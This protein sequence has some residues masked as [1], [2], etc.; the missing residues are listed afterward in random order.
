MAG[1]I[2]FLPESLSA[3]PRTTSPDITSNPNEIGS[4]DEFLR[5]LASLNAERSAESTLAQPAGNAAPTQAAVSTSLGA[6][7]IELPAE[8]QR[9]NNDAEIAAPQSQLTKAPFTDLAETAEP[10]T[11]EASRE[12]LS[13]KARS[14]DTDPIGRLDTNTLE[15]KNVVIAARP[16]FAEIDLANP[17]APAP[18]LQAQ[19][20]S[21][22]E[23]VPPTKL[24]S[25]EPLNPL[26]RRILPAEA[27]SQFAPTPRGIS[28]SGHDQNPRVEAVTASPQH[29]EIN[30]DIEIR[31]PSQTDGDVPPA[32][33][34]LR[35]THQL[36]RMQTVAAFTPFQQN[37][38]TALPSGTIDLP[39]SGE[40]PAA[41]VDPS[42]STDTGLLKDADVDL[43]KSA[44]ADLPKTAE[45][46]PAQTVEARASQESDIGLARSIPTDRAS[47]SKPQSNPQTTI[48]ETSPNAPLPNAPAQDVD[49]PITSPLPA[50]KKA[51]DG[52]R[53]AAGTPSHGEPVRGTLNTNR[54]DASSGTTP[55]VDPVGKA[56]TDTPTQQVTPPQPRPEPQVKAVDR[57]GSF[58]SK[59]P[60]AA[61]QTGATER[62]SSEPVSADTPR[63]QQS[64]AAVLPEQSVNGAASTEIARETELPAPRQVETART[65]DAKPA[66]EAAPLP[67]PQS[68]SAETVPGESKQVSVV[69]TTLGTSQPSQTQAAARVQAPTFAA[70]L[71]QAGTVIPQSQ[72]ADIPNVMSDALSLEDGSKKI[73]VQLDPPEL[74]RVSID[75]KFDGNVL[76][77]VLVTG[78]TPEAMRRLRLMHFELVQTLESHGFSGQDLDFSQRGDDRRAQ[79]LFQNF[80]EGAQTYSQE[81]STDLA[82]MDQVAARQTITTEGLNLKL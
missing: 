74:G 49:A 40:I 62:A 46:V 68:L 72:V 44:E 26:A 21:E 61:A 43:I 1:Q 4:G 31:R 65:A 3:E 35:P 7:R 15:P 24:E 67:A 23:N 56:E 36:S 45:I 6:S 57:T 60:N 17:A 70:Q 50:N 29:I 81:D 71:Q 82:N 28:T 5:T 12:S 47:A 75:F 18:D 59:T 22:A 58:Q 78:E 11:F 51:T 48:Q 73:T 79:N 30:Q 76:Q 20:P 34:Q 69:E 54:F 2:G 19:V 14:N 9:I 63:R 8:F 38:A 80:E 55:I 13:L 39:Q 42:E 41:I 77:N 64:D 53:P 37:A 25:A 10:V 52:Q 33:S 66:N 16:E 32:P 27:E